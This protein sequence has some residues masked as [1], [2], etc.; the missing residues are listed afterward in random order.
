LREPTCF[1]IASNG[2]WRWPQR[3]YYPVDQVNSLIR[4]KIIDSKNGDAFSLVSEMEPGAVSAFSSLIKYLLDSGVQ[5]EFFMAPVHPAY[6]ELFPGEWEKMSEVEVTLRGIATKY[7][8]RTH[9][10]FDPDANLCRPDEYFDG[11][12][13]RK[14]CAERILK[15]AFST[16]IAPV[17]K[18]GPD[19]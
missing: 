19:E 18:A 8:I 14:S 15:S 5:I 1:T 6:K 11:V 10:T 4:Q 16:R 12:H 7:N 13:P 17:F 2:V 9:G 3:Y